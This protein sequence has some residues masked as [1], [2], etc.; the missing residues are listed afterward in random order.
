MKCPRCNNDM[1]I[2]MHFE[3]SKD[4]SFHECP[5]CKQRTHQKRINYAQFEK[6]ETNE[7]K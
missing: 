6:E 4:Y 5:K 2:I 7:K 3:D 1:K